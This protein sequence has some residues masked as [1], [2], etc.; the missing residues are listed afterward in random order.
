M[1]TFLMNRSQRVKMNDRYSALIQLCPNVK[2]VDDGTM[3]EVCI[4]GSTSRS[5]YRY[6]VINWSEENYMCINSDKTKEML[7]CF[8]RPNLHV[9]GNIA[10][11]VS[12]SKVLCIIVSDDLFWNAHVQ[13]LVT[14]AGKR[15]YVLCQLK[16]AGAGE[17]K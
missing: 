10:E 3:Y 12:T 11:R 15:M 4:V 9:N 14:K 6:I 2:Y 17:S 1:G 13:S 16:R 8:C 5:Q 7:I